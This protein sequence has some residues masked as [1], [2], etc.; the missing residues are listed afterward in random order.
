MEQNNYKKPIEYLLKVLNYNEYKQLP[1]DTGEKPPFI[2]VRPDDVAKGKLTSYVYKYLAYEHEA[3]DKKPIAVAIVP[4]W[5]ETILVNTKESSEDTHES[6]IPIAPMYISTK[7]NIDGSLDLTNA[8]PEWATCLELPNNVDGVSLVN[9]NKDGKNGTPDNT[10]WQLF[11]ESIHQLYR[12]RYGISWES[13]EITDSNNCSHPIRTKNAKGKTCYWVMRADSVTGTKRNIIKL[14]KRLN[15]HPSEINKLFKTMLGTSVDSENG[16]PQLGVNVTEHRGQMKNEYPLADAQRHAI[17]CM[18]KLTNGN[19]LAVSG[20]PGTGKT[21]MLQSVVAS[22]I[23]EQAM[24]NAPKPPII[25]ATSVNNKAITNVIDAF[26]IDDE[27]K[28]ASPLFTRWIRFNDTPLPLAVYLPS[29]MAKDKDKFFCSSDIGGGDYQILRDSWKECKSYFIDMARK[30]GLSV[31]NDIP[32]MK[33]VIHGQLQESCGMLKRFERSLENPRKECSSSFLRKIIAFLKGGGMDY[34]S[35]AEMEDYLTREVLESSAEFKLLKQDI[36]KES[37]PEKRQTLEIKKDKFITGL[38]YKEG[39]PFMDYADR[40]LDRC[41][42]FKCFW[43]AVHY[44]EA[45]WLEQVQE[46]PRL[47][48]SK[49]YRSEVYGEMAFVCPCIVATFFRAPKCFKKNYDAN[50]GPDYL[51]DFIDLLIVDEAGQACTEIGLPTFAL[52][53]KAIVVGDEDQ[54]PPIYS[55]KT[56]TS[57][58]N[59]GKDPDSSTYKL[60]DCSSSSI[61][62]VA[63]KQSAFNRIWSDGEILEG[64]FLEE[65]RRCYDDIIAYCNK[66]IYKGRLKPLAGNPKDGESVLPV[67]GHLCVRH[68]NS[69]TPPTGSRR[70]REEAQAIAQWIKQNENI[71]RKENK[72]KEPKEVISV[73]TPFTLQAKLIREELSKVGYVYDNENKENDKGIPVGTVHTFQGAES[74]I[75]I[76]STVYGFEEKFS[77]VDGNRELMN[78]AVSRAKKHFFLFSSKEAEQVEKSD[79]PFN[80]LLRM[81]TATVKDDYS[82]LID[83]R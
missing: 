29:E 81:T 4:K 7:I 47:N 21:T 51:Y 12:S 5:I 10:N 82:S 37:D 15:D 17:H 53:K 66:L 2:D 59:W 13:E 11:I 33:R 28:V 49:Q 41:L 36:D 43:L 50:E 80:L 44:F 3:K 68:A 52:A 61:M 20:P 74:P 65:H 57:R 1:E 71:I 14:I 60:I 25:L 30:S 48:L 73:I 39:T 38:K 24:K 79:S 75:V 83:P 26:K 22:L 67:M 9:K 35:E 42:R 55:I 69:E 76:Y 78:V 70:S 56:G 27:G 31:S 54:I 40:M 58:E 46:N 72:G 8:K 62:R 16:A 63:S 18:T 6:F 64:L 32:T 77:F 23:V 34:M 19:V 45:C